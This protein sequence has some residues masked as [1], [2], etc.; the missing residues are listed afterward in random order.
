MPVTI[1]DIASSCGLSIYAV[2][3]VLNDKPIYLV[4]AKRQLIVE[5][6]K[7]MGYTPNIIARNLRSK[8]SSMVGFVV[9]CI[10][11]NFHVQLIQDL[12]QKFSE[13][14]YSFIIST[15]RYGKMDYEYEQINNML[16]LG[17]E[18]VLVSSRFSLYESPEIMENYAASL[19][20]SG[21]I[22][23]IDSVI[24]SDKINYVCTDNR[25]DTCKA[26]SV[27][28]EKGIRAFK[29]I[30]AAVPMPY[31]I[32][33]RIEGM[34]D[35]CRSHNI[36]FSE[37]DIRLFEAR[38]HDGEIKKLVD[39]IAEPSL[40]FFESFS[41]YFPHFCEAFFQ[42]GLKPGKDIFIS[43][44][45]QPYIREPLSFYNKYGS[46]FDIK[47]PF[48]Q[49]NRS[50]FAEEALN[51]LLSDRKELLRKNVNSEFINFDI[52]GDIQL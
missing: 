40:I 15:P 52:L 19:N 9:N 24:P 48:L 20:S 27:F 13:N 42:K 33:Q 16:N 22:L 3:R 23:F 51:F 10:S 29:F 1:K 46:F 28:A 45:D 31:A 2:S 12:N 30:R 49:Q 36:A 37:E 47:I 17:C 11:D 39:E 38:N 43:G 32:H 25:N 26:V 5:T 21:R 41:S 35:A 18:I 6:A 14:G 50:V 7:K 4:D 44:F 34:K 8:K